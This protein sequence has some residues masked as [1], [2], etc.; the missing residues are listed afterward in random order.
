M[1]LLCTALFAWLTPCF[2][3]QEVLL[4]EVVDLAPGESVIRSL[5]I[6]RAGT[7]HFWAVSN[8]LDPSLELMNWADLETKYDED[9]GGGDAPFLAWLVEPGHELELTLTAED[10]GARGPVRLVAVLAF[11]TEEGLEVAQELERR[12]R[13]IKQLLGRGDYAGVRTTVR[14]AAGLVERAAEMPGPTTSWRL[15]ELGNSA[16]ACGEN[17]LAVDCWTS[18]L[19]FR[20]RWYP[21]LHSN[22]LNAHCVLGIALHE[23]GDLARARS[24][25][26]Q[27]HAGIL[28]RDPLS[29][30]DLQLAHLY[31]AHAHKDAGELY[32]AMELY[33]R[34]LGEAGSTDRAE[35]LLWNAH[36]NAADLYLK[37]GDLPVAR[38]LAEEALRQ[39]TSLESVRGADLAACR[40]TLGHVM[41]RQARPEEQDRAR[42][43]IERAVEGFTLY[44]GPVNPR[45]LSA[46]ELLAGVVADGE[47][48]G[49]AAELREEIAAAYAAARPE[50]H[51]D[52]VNA[53]I[54]AS[55][56]RS[57][58]E[59]EDDVEERL[60]ALV[61]RL[62]PGG[63]HLH[64]IGA[65]R[66]LLLL[67]VRKEDRARTLEAFHELAAALRQLLREGAQT[68]LPREAESIAS[69]TAV[70]LWTA[71]SV[72][73]ELG[74]FEAPLGLEEELFT[75]VEFTRSASRHAAFLRRTAGDDPRLASVRE[76][77]RQSRA[78]YV[79][80]VWAG[81]PPAR[82]IELRM[83]CEDLER[84]LLSQLAERAE[85]PA[86]D[87]T[88]SALRAAL[89]ERALVSY[90]EYEEFDP[91]R[92]ELRPRRK[93]QLLAFVL[94][95]GRPLTR[96]ELD[97]A[98]EIEEAAAR[99]AKSVQ[100]GNEGRAATRGQ[101]LRRLVLDPVLD[102]CAGA[103][104]LVAVPDGV[105]HEIPLDA[106]PLDQDFVGDSYS[107]QIRSTA[108]ELLEEPREALG[109]PTLVALGGI[110]YGAGPGPESEDVAAVREGLGL[111]GASGPLQPLPASA[112][113]VKR[114][115]ELFREH[116]GDGARL[117][118]ED[119]AGRQALAEA[120]GATFL[121]VA[122]HGYFPSWALPSAGR[123]EPLDPAID[124]L[125]GQSSAARVRAL[126]PMALAS[127]A[128]AGANAPPDARGRRNGLLT[129]EELS[130]YDFAGCELAVLSGCR[131]HSGLRVPGQGVASLQEALHLAG[132]RSVLASPWPVKDGAAR[133]LMEAFY[134]RLWAEDATKAEALWGAKTELRE[135]GRPLRDWASWILT[136]DPGGS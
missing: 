29:H 19:A 13:A 123:P 126:S 77:L 127:L 53:A 24:L 17:S 102:Q 30:G 60:A 66:R 56:T 39:A 64:Q 125:L 40:R 110:D 62:E 34:V 3:A 25:F 28:A 22:L 130:A 97:S 131:T 5:T 37:L 96:V 114:I 136:G 74:P 87:P 107:L 134:R 84:K 94:A 89:G 124:G 90:W 68:S 1:R 104:T 54:N 10:A 95:P 128:L 106:L 65:L 12:L 113:E 70:N 132:A 120:A 41:S 98:R 73:G 75:L 69:A 122:T 52:V 4:D 33:L 119:S 2:P 47:D 82:L 18:L 81:E 103:R 43:L 135:R 93:R 44:L 27:F 7:A 26:E 36:L 15:Y 133:E 115:A 63:V 57:L 111:P 85:L 78:E 16:R 61:D 76:D 71:L 11:D 105:L 32:E 118:G 101:K 51:P 46:R 116:V 6:G 67:Q 38:E 23:T 31:L 91:T 50:D 88:P 35:E 129:A 21:A 49:R 108:W 58:V 72:A 117:I 14:G 92:S 109:D 121:H 20:E 83:A 9:S 42:D 55:W 48:L 99:W 100:D 79:A 59:G 80:A 112:E 8:A 86:L 45:T